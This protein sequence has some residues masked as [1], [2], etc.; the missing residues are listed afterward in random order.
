MNAVTDIR[1][2]RETVDG[3][4]GEILD[5]AVS[6]FAAEGYA[7]GS[8]RRIAEEVGLSEPALYRYFSGKEDLFV[9]LIEQTGLRIRSEVAPL[10]ESA[11]PEGLHVV[12]QRLLASRRAVARAYVPVIQTILVASAH[13]PAFLS[14]YSSSLVEPMVEQL[15]SVVPEF[16]AYFHVDSTPEELPGRVRMLMSLFAGY[17]VMSYVFDAEELPVGDAIMRLMGWNEN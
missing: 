5:A 11:A 13:N 6:V 15:S 14:A 17:F 16:D 12:A 1:F 2:F 9:T 4:K 3:R 10:L 8:M 7:G